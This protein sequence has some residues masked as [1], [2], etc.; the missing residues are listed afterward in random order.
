MRRELVSL[1]SAACLAG[2]VGCASTQAG[3]APT[4]ASQTPPVAAPTRPLGA[5]TQA[6]QAVNGGSVSAGPQA[7]SSPIYFAFDSDALTS[8]SQ[9][10]LRQMAEYLRAR[11]E[12]GLTIEGHCDETGSNEYNLAL[13]DRRANAARAYL[14]ALGVE[15]RRIKTVSYGEEKPAV[16]GND[17]D[18]HAKNRRGQFDLKA[19]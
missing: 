1:V 12:A 9:S 10:V 16:A 7:P 17:D 4:L 19:S 15:D 6:L 2:A 13:G 3:S 5:P 8:E 11:P 14:R 18:A